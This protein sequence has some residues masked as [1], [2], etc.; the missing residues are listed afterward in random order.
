MVLVGSNLAWCHPVLYQRLLAARERRAGEPKL[1]VIDP[2][3]TATCDAAETHLPL[4]PGSDTAL[5][6]G[7]LV[8]LYQQDR[9]ATEFL[10]QHVAGF[11]PAYRA[12]KEVAPSVP[13]VAAKTGLP[14]SAIAEF[15]SLW[16]RTRK[17]VTIYSQ[18]VN[19]LLY[20]SRC[21]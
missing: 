3:R 19:C 5:F 10:E 18:G 1:V 11:W 21:V 14:E 8:H 4:K 12:A 20:T 17:V 9:L 7:L 2:R 15:Y 16:G 6:N 13:A